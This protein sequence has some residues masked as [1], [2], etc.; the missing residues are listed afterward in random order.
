MGEY[1]HRT[2]GEVKTQGEWR[3]AHRNTS[4]PKVWTQATLDSLQLDAVLEA[5]KPDAGQY[6]TVVRNGVTQDAKGNWVTAWLVQ[7]MFADDAD[8]TKAEKEAA[9]QASLDAVAAASVRAKRNSLL[10]ETDY[11]AL[12]DNTL[13]DITMAYRQALRDITNHVN[14]PYLTDADWPVK[15]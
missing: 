12:T 13:D 9:Y 4:F 7:D 15:P 1:R 2:T 11:L 3:A 6:Q 8:G 5:P 10:A 14:F